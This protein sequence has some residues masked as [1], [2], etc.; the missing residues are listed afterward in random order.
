MRVCI[1]PHTKEVV[2][3]LLSVLSCNSSI[4]SSPKKRVSESEPLLFTFGLLK[5]EKIKGDVSVVQRMKFKKN[6]IKQNRKP[7]NPSLHCINFPVF[8]QRSAVTER[9]PS[10]NSSGTD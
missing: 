2:T 5:K 10:F 9:E 6:L 7:L 3:T 8:Q 4:T 1:L